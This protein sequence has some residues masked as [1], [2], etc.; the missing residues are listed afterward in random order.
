MYDF[1]I[2]NIIKEIAGNKEVVITCSPVT[3]Y[4]DYD[5]NEPR[6]CL[7]ISGPE[8]LMKRLADILWEVE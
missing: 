1:E 8:T 3:G 4:L 6:Y 7:K 5:E 2:A